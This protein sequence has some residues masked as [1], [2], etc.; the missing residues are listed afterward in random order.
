MDAATTF[1]LP[2]CF[3]QILNRSFF[4]L[5]NFGIGENYLELL[6]GWTTVG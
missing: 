4:V 1:N 6:A 3:L 2:A 5:I